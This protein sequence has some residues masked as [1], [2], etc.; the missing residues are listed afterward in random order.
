MLESDDLDD[1]LLNVLLQT[2]YP[3]VYGET[4]G[5]F[6]LPAQQYQGAVFAW[7]GRSRKSAL[8]AIR[9]ASAGATA[10]Q[11]KRFGAAGLP[12]E[13]ALQLIPTAARHA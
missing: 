1:Y 13:Y 10:E 4:W 2:I 7:L 9:L 8:E 12:L 3:K 6:R 5:L 11:V